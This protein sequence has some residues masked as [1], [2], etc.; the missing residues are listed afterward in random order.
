MAQKERLDDILE[1]LRTHGYVT[2]KFLTETLHYSTATIN[3]D[4]NHLQEQQLVT[5]SY[6]GVELVKGERNTLMFR[7]HKMRAAKN[8][9]GKCAATYIHDGDTV[10]IDGTTTSQCIAPHILDRKDITVITNNVALVAQ[11]SERG[12]RVVCLGGAVVDAPY[13]LGGVDT[14]DNAEKYRADKLFFSTG[15]L[16]ED[17]GIGGAYYPLLKVLIRNAKQRYFLVDHKKF[18]VRTRDVRLS[19]R[20]VDCVICDCEI[21]PKLQ[22]KFPHVQFVVAND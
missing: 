1:I 8:L 6:G 21:E 15:S 9:I 3:R 13:I 5:R 19:L 10:F 20:D 17:G 11:L 2:V 18:G 4:L 7:Y 22:E 12:V 16:D 14:V